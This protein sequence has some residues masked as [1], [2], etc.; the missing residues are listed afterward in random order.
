MFHSFVQ[1]I[2]VT[3]ADFTRLIHSDEIVKAVRAPKG[4]KRDGRAKRNPLKS[5]RQ[6]VK[7]NP[8]AEVSYFAFTTEW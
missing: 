7:L 2:Q 6:M 5:T 3:C 4:N 8:Y 1:L